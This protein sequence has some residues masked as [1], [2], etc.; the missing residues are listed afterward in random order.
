MSWRDRPY[1]GDSDGQGC[2]PMSM[3]F[4]R[5]SRMVLWLIVANVA[6]FFIDV[7]SRNA[8]PTFF[9]FTFGLSGAGILSGKIWQLIT[10]MFLHVDAMHLLLNMLGLYVCG[11][12]L[13]Q[14]L[15]RRRFLR[16][17]AICGIVGGIGYLALPFFDAMVYHT[18]VRES[19]HYIYPLRGASGAVYGLL[20]AAIVFF[21]HIQVILFIIPVPIRVF[22]LI[23]AGILLLNIIMPGKMENRGGEVCHVLGAVAGLATFYFWGMLPRLRKGAAWGGE[24]PAFPAPRSRPGFFERRRQGAWA[25]KQKAIAAEEAEVDRI[26]A[27]VRNQGM[28]SLTRKEKKILAQATRRQQQREDENQRRA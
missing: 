3:G 8:S 21:P 18:P 17:Y 14:S 5:P 12:E 25:R 28:A 6:V 23:L 16:Y 1:S 22:G 24:G 10:Y 13:E 19:F 4:R 11:T 9:M 15:G 27:K 26:L 2:A 20:L 7:L